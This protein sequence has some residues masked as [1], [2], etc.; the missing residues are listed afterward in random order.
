MQTE[1]TIR[2]LA[3]QVHKR[4]MALPAIFFLEMYKPLSGVAHA[5]ALVSSPMLIPFFGPE[6]YEAALRVVGSRDA[7][8]QL[9]QEIE[10]LEEVAKGVANG[11]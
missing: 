5:A 8:E 6:R 7:L 1:A 2:A 3:T 11:N 4:G 9:I 10:R